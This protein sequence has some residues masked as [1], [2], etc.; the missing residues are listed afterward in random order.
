MKLAA[1]T[2]TSEHDCPVIRSNKISVDPWLEPFCLLKLDF[3]LN[4]P[5]GVRKSA[6]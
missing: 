4:N 3:A 1:K 5:D 6:R 2:A